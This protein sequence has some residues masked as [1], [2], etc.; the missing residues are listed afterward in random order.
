MPTQVKERRQYFRHPISVPIQLRLSVSDR[1]FVSNSSDISLGGLNFSWSKKL[2]K[3]T[4][5][6]IKIPVKEKSFDVRAKVVY[7]K[8]DRKTA[9]YHTGVSFTDFPSAF[10]AKLAEEVLQILEFRKSLSREL[11]HEISEEEAARKWISEFAES[12]PSIG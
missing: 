2:S 11:G 6:D 9:R 12:F 7:S 10:K 5:L 3:G 4:M 1:S 8:E